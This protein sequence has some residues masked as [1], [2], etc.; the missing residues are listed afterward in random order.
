ML[1]VAEVPARGQRAQPAMS[2]AGAAAEKFALPGKRK[3]A[4]EGRLRARNRYA[5]AR[6]PPRVLTRAEGATGAE[7]RV[8]GAGLPSV[9]RERREGRPLNCLRCMVCC[10]SRAPAAALCHNTPSCATC[11][12]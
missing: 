7:S 4:G 2:A 8:G 1:R 3:K 6:A 11:G 5:R 12:W 9:A 10:A